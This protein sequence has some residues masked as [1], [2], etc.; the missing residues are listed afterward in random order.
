MRRSHKRAPVKIGPGEAGFGKLEQVPGDTFTQA[1]M[2]DL[3]G[4]VHHPV[5][6]LCE[7]ATKR[8]RFLGTDCFGIDGTHHRI[9]EGDGLVVAP[10]IGQTSLAKIISR[11][12]RRCVKTWPR[13][14]NLITRT[15]PLSSWNI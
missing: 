3:T 2:S 9:T 15:R 11:K 4:V 10:M 7:V 8:L 1:L 5:Q 13:A 12:T 14:E 6:L